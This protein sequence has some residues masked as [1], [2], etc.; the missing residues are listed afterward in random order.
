MIGCLLFSYEN[1]A[2]NEQLIVADPFQHGLDDSFGQT[3]AGTE[4]EGSDS[5]IEERKF[6]ITL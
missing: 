6:S 1:L 5:N 2:L 4:E 3:Q